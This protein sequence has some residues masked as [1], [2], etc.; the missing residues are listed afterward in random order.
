MTGQ[1]AAEAVVGMAAGG[2]EIAFFEVF[3]SILNALAAGSQEATGNLGLNLLVVHLYFPFSPLY[4][5]S[6]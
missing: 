1:A 4:C 2:E 3:D 6:V 5:L